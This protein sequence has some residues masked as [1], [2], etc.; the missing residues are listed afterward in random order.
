MEIYCITTSAIRNFL[1][2]IVP[3]YTKKSGLYDA[4]IS[5]R[6][7]KTAIDPDIESVVLQLICQTNN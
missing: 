4:I 2:T 7:Y 5:K 3:V 6:Q 1:I